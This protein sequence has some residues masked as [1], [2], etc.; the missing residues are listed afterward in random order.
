MD[1]T[2]KEK[3]WQIIDELPGDSSFDEVLKELAMH[4]LIDRGLDDLEQDRVQSHEQVK[5]LFLM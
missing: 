5:R 3:A 4:R 2:A 1:M